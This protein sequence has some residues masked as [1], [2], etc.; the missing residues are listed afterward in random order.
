MT[1]QRK[2]EVCQVVDHLFNTFSTALHQT[3]VMS[4]LKITPI[5]QYSPDEAGVV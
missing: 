4:N 5:R 3:I 2:L 1:Q